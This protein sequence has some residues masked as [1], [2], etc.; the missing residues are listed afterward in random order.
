MKAEQ[1][2]MSIRVFINTAALLFAFVN[3]IAFANKVIPTPEQTLTNY[4]VKLDVPSLAAALS[5]N[6]PAVRENAAK[7]L[8]ARGD[9]SVVPQLE[10]LLADSYV[11]A[12]LAAAGAL[13]KLGEAKGIETLRQATKQKDGPTV[14]YAS[15]ELIQIGDNYGYDAVVQIAQK[16]TTALDRLIA[17]DLLRDYASLAGVPKITRVLAKSMREDRD[18]RV[19]G[20]AAHGLSTLKHPDVLKVFSGEVNNKDEVVKGIAQQYVRDQGR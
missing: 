12:R 11:Y 1:A 20:A 13:A 6:E 5:R 17:V 3:S 15:R 8:G 16:S 4:G 18:S 14:I 19:R 10:T 7:L 2:G 9:R